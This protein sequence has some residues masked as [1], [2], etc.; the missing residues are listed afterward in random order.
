MEAGVAEG[1]E[2]QFVG[3]S[4]ACLKVTLRAALWVTGIL[5]R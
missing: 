3:F 1:A 2:E 5:S 4:S